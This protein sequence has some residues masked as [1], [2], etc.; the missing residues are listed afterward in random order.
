MFDL[1]THLI[2]HQDRS[3]NRENI[4]D[5]LEAARCVG[6]QEI[7]FADHDM[8]YSD[9]DLPLIREVAEGYPDLK[10]R[11]GLEVDYREED[12][13][14]I[15]SLLQ[16]FPFDYVIGSVHEIKNWLFDYPDQAQRHHE[17]DPDRIYLAYF[18]LVEKAARSQLF[19]TIGH[20]DLIK[21]FGVRPRTDVRELAGN[22]LKAIAE[23]GLVAE[24][25]T[26]GRYKPVGEFY[27][28]EKLIR[29]MVNQGIEFTLGSD[30]HE[31]QYVGRD[32][33][34]GVQLLQACGVKRL[35]HFEQQKRL[36]FNFNR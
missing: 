18:D 3:A 34:E 24:L 4:Q 35:I 7:G 28:E 11:V 2:G 25:N 30:A 23:N 32:L 12:E 36:T 9:L 14:K 29:E 20:F 26:A 17:E 5:Y 1:H 21:L 8:Y 33:R 31:A 22:A 15:Q 27:P 16:T 10:V 19:T 13:E 6:L